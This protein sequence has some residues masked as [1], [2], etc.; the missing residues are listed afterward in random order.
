MF[1]DCEGGVEADGSRGGG[2]L[3]DGCDDREGVGDYDGIE[4]GLPRVAPQ[5]Y[6]D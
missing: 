5:L 1:E 2:G 3:L 6:Q 4:A